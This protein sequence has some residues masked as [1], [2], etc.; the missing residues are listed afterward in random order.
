VVSRRGQRRT[1][2]IGH[3]LGFDRGCH[4]VGF[5]EP[6]LVERILSLLK[7]PRRISRGASR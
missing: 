3:D 7:K 1:A 5:V 6:P 2:E 4:G